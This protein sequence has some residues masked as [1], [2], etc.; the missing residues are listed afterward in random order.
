[1]LFHLVMPPFGRC[2]FGIATA[3]FLGLH[4]HFRHS[5][6]PYI[7]LIKAKCLRALNILKFLS[8]PKTGCNR[9][10][11]LNLYTSLVRAILDYGSPIY[12]MPSPSQLKLLDT[13]QNSVIRCS[14]GAFRTSSALTLW[15]EAGIPPPTQLPLTDFYSQVPY[16]HPPIS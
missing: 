13:I 1:M 12:G 14:T 5:W 16:R 3:R 2:V 7:K 6:V 11:L 9:N 10:N 8:L 15:A 4:F